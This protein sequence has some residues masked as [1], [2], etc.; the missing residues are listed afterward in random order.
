MTFGGKG[1]W[2]VV[3]ELGA[4]RGRARSS[5]RALDAGVNFIDT[6][7]VYSEGESERLLGKALGG[8]PRR[9]RRRDQGARP[10]SGPGPN[11]VGLSRGHILAASTASLTRL[12][13]DYVD[14]YQIHG[15][16][17]LD[18]DRGDAARARRRGARRQGALRR[19]LEPA[20]RGSS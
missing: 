13:T 1:F 19:L 20:R 5:A 15:F 4:G 2:S 7:D 6:A 18:A 10:R 9:R 8:A 12:G 3:G 16:D 11:E 17:P 14:L